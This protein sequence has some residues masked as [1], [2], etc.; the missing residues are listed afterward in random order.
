M[1]VRAGIDELRVD[2]DPVAGALHTAFEHGDHVQLLRD[3]AHRLVRVRILHHRGSRDD[4]QA[5]DLGQLGEQVVVDARREI[6]VL[7]VRAAGLEGQYRDGGL[8]GHGD[9]AIR[10]TR[11]RRRALRRSGGRVGR[12]LRYEPIRNQ[13]TD[14]EHEQDDDQRIDAAARVGRRRLAGLFLPEPF[15]CD[16][17]DPGEYQ[18][19]DEKQDEQPQH[20]SEG[21]VGRTEILEDHVGNLQDQPR[22]RNVGDGDAEYVAP[23]EFLE[24]IA[25]AKPPSGPA[26]ALKIAD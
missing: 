8:V 23:S 1:L 4:L 6:G 18:R 10:R 9:R 22:H 24:K 16:L 11:L 26:Q 20:Q 12:P 19:R 25:Q 17:V 14:R 13:P 3:L 2:A 7:R 21:P 5:V 15:G